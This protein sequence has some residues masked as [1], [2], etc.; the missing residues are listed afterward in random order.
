MEPSLKSSFKKANKKK[1]R[2]NDNHPPTGPTKNLDFGFS[3]ITF[4][5]ISLI[6]F[7]LSGCV[8]ISTNLSVTGPNRLNISLDVESIS[9]SS[10]PWQIEFSNHLS[11][12]HDVIKVEIEEGKQH[13]QS[14]P[15]RFEDANELLKQIASV[16]SETSG[17]DIKQPEIITNKR[18][19]LIGTKQNLKFLFDLQEL[20]K[21]PG[22]KINIII[23]GIDNKNNF[24]TKPLEATYKNDSI[25]LPLKIGQ[26][27]QLE[28]SYWKWSQISIGFIVIISLTLLSIFLQTF[29][30]KMG[31]GFPELPP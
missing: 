3:I 25:L 13:Y 11:K 1:V 6:A 29:R 18:N 15:I 12:N 16:A 27:N 28:V 8:D 5:I 4:L 19:W 9:G 26:F 7:L 20:P 14:Q 10:I 31:F 23:N 24:K 30:L 21:I 22:L 17:I 2:K